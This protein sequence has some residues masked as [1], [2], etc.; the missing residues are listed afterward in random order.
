M[1][2][3]CSEFESTPSPK[4]VVRTLKTT[5]PGR[6]VKTE[7][8]GRM[9]KCLPR[10]CQLPNDQVL[11]ESSWWNRS[12]SQL[13]RPFRS[14]KSVIHS[15]SHPAT[16]RPIEVHLGGS[17]CP[18]GLGPARSQLSKH[19]RTAATVIKG[20]LDL[21][22]TMLTNTHQTVRGFGDRGAHAYKR[23][24]NGCSWRTCAPR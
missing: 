15:S 18:V 17:N 3:K 11:C 9:F 12:A 10:P 24:M 19:R 20:K 7:F 2:I 8:A 5:D 6:S 21:A 13:R 14:S 22:L 23:S 16:G 1:T 4:V